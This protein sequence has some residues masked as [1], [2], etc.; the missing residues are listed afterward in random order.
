MLRGHRDDPILYTTTSDATLRIFMP[1]LDA[2]QY[3]QLHT[4]LDTFSS[5]PF[6]V[7][8]QQ[9]ASAVFWLDREVLHA[10]L[11][12]ILAES[13]TAEEDARR[14]RVR[15]I[16]EEGWDLFLRVL[17]DGSL[18]VQAVAV[19]SSIKDQ[20]YIS[21]RANLYLRILTVDRP[22]CSNSSLCSRQL[23]E[24]CPRLPV[25]YTLCLI[26]GRVR[27]P[28]SPRPLSLRMNSI[29]SHSSTP[30]QMG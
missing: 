25:T 10:A 20:V 22:H 11:K 13:Q 28:S 12:V 26:P 5:L 21:M 2:P 8:S 1:V 23:L 9:A 15:E 19:G 27:S 6:S 29:C 17:G 7:A 24:L 14:R 3:L 4:A 18:V 16:A 30:G